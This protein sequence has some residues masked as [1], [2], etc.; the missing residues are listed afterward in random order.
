M[1]L[2]L[3]VDI[4]LDGPN[5]IKLKLS[6]PVKRAVT[7]Q[8]PVLDADQMNALRRGDSLEANVA[9]LVEAVSAWFLGKDLVKPVQQAL[10]GKNDLRVVVRVERQL[11]SALS[12]LPVE[13][14]SVPGKA[15]PLALNQRVT[16]L[17]RVLPVVGT[18]PPLDEHDWPLRVLIVRSNPPDLGGGV[19][20]ATPIVERILGEAK[21]AGL[22]D[23]SVQVDVLTSEADGAAAVTWDAFR[24]ALKQRRYDICVYLGHG[25][26]EPAVP[27]APP[28]G[29]LQFESAENRN[30]S[31]AVARDVVSAFAL[32]PVR[33]VLFASCL[34]A[35]AV[36]KNDEEREL[37]QRVTENLPLWL[38]GAQG[39]AQ[40]LVD[41][42]AQVEL[43]VGMRDRLEVDQ[44]TR[45]IGSFFRNLIKV[46]PGDVERAIRE[47]RADLFGQPFPPAW[48]SAIVFSKGP[49]A[50]F[51]FMTEKPA[52]AVFSAEKQKSLDGVKQI[53]QA[54]AQAYIQATTDGASAVG[55]LGIG[56]QLYA[57][58]A[59][60]D[61]MIRPRFLATKAGDVEL[62][63]E[64]LGK[65]TIARLRGKVSIGGDNVAITDEV[66]DERLK[67]LVE[68]N[69]GHDGPTATFSMDVDGPNPVEIAAGPLFTLKATIGSVAPAVH[70][71]TVTRAA[72]EPE[73][74]VW[75][76]MDFI[77][78]IP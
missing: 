68:F 75:S 73:D 27:G 28:V 9:P 30:H 35:A 1:T 60:G 40:A 49:V 67:G 47:A 29:R 24:D 12:D 23:G 37:Q 36:P 8:M 42:D 46:F 77:A 59:G 55:M 76:G 44:A 64:L 21:A 52:Q 11:L 17:V 78:V 58:A 6:E 31:P 72:T 53:R 66:R 22:P 74:L 48:S 32:H 38:R 33:V 63:V 71:V 26:L 4:V 18:T 65:L 5:G 62:T 14:L 50:R 13:L 25:D 69:S 56:A 61:P 15:L 10:N 70:E 20:P 51:E 43:A 7:R 57:A 39:V 45:L 3:A 2:D 41:S 54:T 34:T 16:S 19:P